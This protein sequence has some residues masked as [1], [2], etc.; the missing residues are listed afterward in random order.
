MLASTQIVVQEPRG[1]L[2]ALR[3]P[4]GLTVVFGQFECVEQDRIGG[5][6]R[7]RCEDAEKRDLKLYAYTRL[8]KGC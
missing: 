6:S 3:G 7:N 8:I 2:C 4:E 5:M 1:G